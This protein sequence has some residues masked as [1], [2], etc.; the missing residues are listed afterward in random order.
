M[1]PRERPAAINRTA[2]SNTTSSPVRQTGSAQIRWKEANA[3][4]IHPCAGFSRASIEAPE[5]EVYEDAAV[6]NTGTVMNR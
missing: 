2:S 4:G 5:G 6:F 3:T 1:S